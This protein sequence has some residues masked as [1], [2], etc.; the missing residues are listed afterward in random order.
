MNLK[1]PS[2][3]FSVNGMGYAYK[4]TAGNGMDIKSLLEKSL[5]FKGRLENNLFFFYAE[6]LKC[7]IQLSTSRGSVHILGL[8]L[9][10]GSVLGHSGSGYVHKGMIGAESAPF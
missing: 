10:K 5:I 1:V 9:S 8:R 6:I 2:N 4:I 7:Q 3:P